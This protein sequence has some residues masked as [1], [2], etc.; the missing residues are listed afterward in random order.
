M[1]KWFVSAKRADFEEIGK[2]F[3]ISPVLARIIRNRDIIGNSS[4]D[5][6]LHGSQKDYYEAGLMKDM[7]KTTKLL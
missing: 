6:Y 1:A 2:T 7:N 3:G 5:K 4:I